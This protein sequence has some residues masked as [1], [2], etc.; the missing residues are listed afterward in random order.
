VPV[1]IVGGSVFPPV[2]QLSYLLT[3]P[4]YGFFWF[5]LAPEAE[6]PGWHRPAPE[7]L[8]DVATIVIRHDITEVLGFSGRRVL[9]GEAL[10]AYLPKRRWFA[11]KGERLGA[12]SVAHTASLPAVP[13]LLLAEIQIAIEGRVESY[14][15]PL[16]IA[17]EG[18]D[19]PPLAQQLALARIRCG[20]RMGVITDG[21]AVD[22][23]ARGVIAALRRGETLKLSEGELRFLPTSRADG[24]TLAPEAE[25]RRFSAEQSNSSLVIGDAVVLK[26][27]RHVAAGI[28]P[29]GEMTRYLTERGFANSPA[30][31][32]EV[33]R[34]APDGT[35]H[36]LMLAQGFVRNQGDGWTWTQDFLNRA[37]EEIA[38]TGQEEQ[39][40]EEAFPVY[41]AFAAA[42]GTRLA[43]MHA[44]LAAPSD[45]PD[46]APIPADAAARGGWAASAIAQLRM[47]FGLLRARTDWLDT[48]SQLLAEGLLGQAE[49]LEAAARRLAAQGAGAIQTRIHGDPARPTEQRR[50]KSSGLRDVAG[51]L[52][53]FDY[54]A[55]AAAQS[56]AAL[57]PQAAERHV[58]LLEQFR[59]HAAASLLDA[60]RAV[61]ANAAHPWVTLAAEKALLD[62]FLIEKAA[63]EIRYESA[64]RPSWLRIPLR[65]LQTI[66]ERVLE[67]GAAP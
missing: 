28:H 14:V 25:I 37:V 26:I 2:G 62:L 41:R 38:V 52:R 36:T 31:F 56:H 35:P 45:D 59:I 15:L 57:A 51:I 44:V 19:S 65:G 24:L 30:L 17:W 33:V 39:A 13:G 16:A 8:P 47:A 50:L 12:P 23:F 54:A 7:V 67:S 1:D 29:E 46:F 32:G 49:A 48:E 9:E 4:P 10:P 11:A 34:V 22:A 64:N 27:L 43:E 6:L 55:A 3:L 18:S 53:S 40:H 58:T 5:L 42:I 21:F 61:L 66:A 20:R 63:Y 60:Y